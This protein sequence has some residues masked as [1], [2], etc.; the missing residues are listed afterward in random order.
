M[1]EFIIE[2]P[3]RVRKNKYKNNQHHAINLNSYR[4]WHF[5]VETNIKKK[6][7]EIIYSKLTEDLKFNKIEVETQFYLK[8]I[9]KDGSE[10]KTRKDK[11]NVYAIALKYFLDALVEKKVLEDDNDNFVKREVI[12][13]SIPV[14]S[15]D[16]EKVIFKIKEL[17]G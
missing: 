17:E 8:T 9:N 16:D 10:S 1:K 6:Y 12:L 13:P 4:N 7:K 14:S 15:P 3:I 5:Q 11:G 2:L